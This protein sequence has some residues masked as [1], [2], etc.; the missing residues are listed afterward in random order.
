MES[1]ALEPLEPSLDRVFRYLEY[2]SASPSKAIEGRILAILPRA[3]QLLEPK[4]L[5]KLREAND[6][7][8][9]TDYDLPM[10]IREAAMFAFGLC[11]VGEAIEEE[12]S[13]LQYAGNL[14]DGMIID[15]IGSAA[16]SELAER[17]GYRVFA[18]AAGRGL[19]ASRAFSPG[20]GA[21]KWS[22][23]NQPLIFA[24]LPA[25]QIGVGFTKTLL[26]RP[27]K[28]LSFIIGVDQ[29]IPQAPAPFSCRG[30]AR[31]D[32]LYRHEPTEVV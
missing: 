14:L 21:S 10:P 12:S 28:S 32:C 13:R 24:N 25:D 1:N 17:L 6:L 4:T 29:Q 2:G 8:R 15:A 11:T 30:C 18:I 19:S 5:L 23:G 9:D 22:I 7:V 27:K 20:A 16:V 3:K 26:M 31:T